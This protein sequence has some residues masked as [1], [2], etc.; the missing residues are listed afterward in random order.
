[1]KSKLFRIESSKQNFGLME[2]AK[3]YRDTVDGLSV[4]EIFEEP[5][6]DSDLGLYP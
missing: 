4:Y 6:D 1:V 2:E 3:S 5:L